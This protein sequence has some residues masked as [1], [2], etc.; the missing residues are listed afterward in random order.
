MKSKD[1]QDIVG[2]L[3]LVAIGLFASLYAQQYEFGDLNR[4]GPGYFPVVLGMILAVLGALIAIPAFMRRGEPVH[5]EYKT[6]ALV[7]AS[8]IAFALTLK[9]LGLVLAT[10]LAVIISS[11]ADRD[12]TWKARI[13]LAVCVAGLTWLV[14]IFGLSMTLP[15]WPWSL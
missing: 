7:M 4:M 10:A 13:I 5:V 9:V 12:I 14:F 8:L 15:T 6:F 11:L 2:G 3:A 1:T